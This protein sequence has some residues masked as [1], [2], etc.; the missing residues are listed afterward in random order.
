MILEY[1]NHDPP[2]A[3]SRPSCACASASVKE[4]A[5]HSRRRWGSWAH[6]AKVGRVQGMTSLT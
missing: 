1:L 6:G 2:K 4:D 5:K 3:E